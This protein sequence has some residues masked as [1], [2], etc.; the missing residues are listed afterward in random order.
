MVTRKGKHTTSRKSRKSTLVEKEEKIKK[1]K[2]EALF[3]AFAVVLNWTYNDV[4][5]NFIIQRHVDGM[6]YEDLAAVAQDI[7]TYTDTTVEFGVTYFYAVSAMNAAG[8]SDVVE[9]SVTV[10]LPLPSPVHNLT[11]DVI[12]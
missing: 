9:V 5:D 7:F 6:Q 12:H 10:T 8:R 11:A 1:E 3:M 4:A 2:E